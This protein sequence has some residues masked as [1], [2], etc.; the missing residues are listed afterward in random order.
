MLAAHDRW[1]VSRRPR[2]IPLIE[3]C[4]LTAGADGGFQVVIRGRHLVGGAMPPQ[5]RIADRS[6]RR[7]EGGDGTLL[8]GVVPH[9][10]P[11]DPVRVDLGPGGEVTTT[12]GRVVPR[13][14]TS[15]AGRPG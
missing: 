10:C 14:D 5:I 13:S 15:G 1:P 7:I 9:G 4:E 12:V 8:R 3:S 11:G 2:P 6:V